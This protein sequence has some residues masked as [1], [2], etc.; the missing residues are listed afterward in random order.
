[1]KI[2]FQIMINHDVFQYLYLLQHYQIL[3]FI[4]TNW[5]HK[6]FI[7]PTI[8]I[9]RMAIVLSTKN[10]VTHCYHSLKM[11]KHYVKVTADFNQIVE[12]SGTE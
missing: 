2:M 3:F 1:M 12:C 11:I 7:S 6:Q 10:L 5:Y 9:K 8:T 4:T